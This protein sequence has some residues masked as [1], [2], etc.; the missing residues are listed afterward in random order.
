MLSEGQKGRPQKISKPNWSKP[1][2]RNHG[3]IGNNSR[4]MTGRKREKGD[5]WPLEHPRIECR[6]NLLVTHRN[7][8]PE[9][10]PTMTTSNHDCTFH[11]RRTK[12]KAN[13]KGERQ[14]SDQ[15]SHSQPSVGHVFSGVNKG[16]G[17]GRISH[18]TFAHRNKQQ[19]C[20]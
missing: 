20:P 14:E 16:P 17:E 9:M 8:N 5:R 4:Q 2:F 7:T 12:R 19:P 10:C 13:R 3:G 1:T 15:S 6:H 18:R 11:L